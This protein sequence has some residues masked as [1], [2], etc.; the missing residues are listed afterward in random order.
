MN[1]II[2]EEELLLEKK[3]T[4]DFTFGF[5]LEAIWITNTYYDDDD[6]DDDD[7]DED[8]ICRNNYGLYAGNIENF[9]IDQG[10]EGGDLHGDCSLDSMGRGVTFEW[11]SPVLPFNVASI[12]KVIK[13]FKKGLGT[14]F[15]VNNSCG[16]HN[17]ISFNDIS[18]EEVIWIMSKLAMDDRAREMFSDFEGIKFVTHWSGDEYLNDLKQAIEENN[19]KKIVSLCSTDKYSV[20]NVHRNKTL[21]WRGPRGF[22]EREDMGI[23]IRFYQRL[24][25]IIKWIIDILDENEINGIDRKNYIDMAMAAL[26]NGNKRIQNF[27]SGKKVKGLLSEESIQKYFNEIVNDNNVLFKFIGTPKPFEQLVQRLYNRDRLGKIVQRLNQAE[28][29]NEGNI[30]LLN[31]VAYKYIP[32][33]MCVDYFDTISKD[34]LDAS[35]KLT[36]ERLLQTS[37]KDGQNI[38]MNQKL[39]ILTKI[40]SVA[41]PDIISPDKFGKL[42]EVTEGWEAQDLPLVKIIFQKGWKSSLSD[43]QSMFNGMIS[44]AEN[45]QQ[46][47]EI[48]ELFKD[49]PVSAKPVFDKLANVIVKYP[50]FLKTLP[51]QQIKLLVYKAKLNGNVEKL[52]KTLV[53]SGIITPEKEVEWNAELTK[54]ATDNLNMNFVDIAGADDEDLG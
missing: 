4:T 21:E 31:N 35:S 23:I 2:T 5:E 25:K 11:A 41:N 49:T 54:N 22:L 18:L 46:I 8:G 44:T 26:P 43:V 14:K 1:D 38:Q 9:F 51:E 16:F 7:Y 13:M 50:D 32:Y 53:T 37:R 29:K 34:T 52:L 42:Y 45:D 19:Y 30:I 48:V 15:E 6:Y 36:L 27:T 40:M 10:L 3:L 47:S 12:E 24:Q 33:R 20:V 17:H 39:G 28:D